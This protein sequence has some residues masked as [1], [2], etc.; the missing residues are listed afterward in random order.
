MDRIR[1]MYI[2]MY[3]FWEPEGDL[4]PV[5]RHRTPGEIIGNLVQS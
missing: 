5:G 1:H 2:C 4:M 3:M